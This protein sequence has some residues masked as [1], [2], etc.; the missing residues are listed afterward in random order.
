MFWIDKNDC[1]WF[2]LEPKKWLGFEVVLGAHGLGHGLPYGRMSHM[3]TLHS[4]VTLDY[5]ASICYTVWLHGHVFEP[6]DL[7]SGHTVV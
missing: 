1:K 5:T 2:G 6:H 4:C 7:G 3:V